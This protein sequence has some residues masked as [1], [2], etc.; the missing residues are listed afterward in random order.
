MLS[1]RCRHSTVL[2]YTDRATT[3][4]SNQTAWHSPPSN[5][6]RR[7]A[8]GLILRVGSRALVTLPRKIHPPEHRISFRF[9]FVPPAPYGP[10]NRAFRIA[11][12]SMR[13]LTC[14]DHRHSIGPTAPGYTS[15]CCMSFDALAT[16]GSS[17]CQ[18]D[19]ATVVGSFVP[20]TVRLQDAS[21][22]LC[23][24]IC[25]GHSSRRKMLHAATQ[26]HLPL[27]HRSTHYAILVRIR[28]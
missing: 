16:F 17:Q 19:A 6:S 28:F 26:S 18:Q 13:C 9:V 23:S 20:R 7:T 21:A 5:R 14:V 27:T 22:S 24:A 2:H 8:T 25:S 4:R 11:R 12:N 15:T 1:A 3:A 10:S